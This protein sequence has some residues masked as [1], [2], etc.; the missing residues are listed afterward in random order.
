MYR[1]F[2]THLA[3]G[4]VLAAV[5]PCAQDTRLSVPP[6][7]LT[8]GSSISV[9]YE[10]GAPNPPSFVDV[11]IHDGGE[12]QQTLRIELNDNGKGSASWTV[13]E[14]S[15]AFFNATGTLEITRFIQ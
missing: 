2:F 5:A 11:T 9:S 4:L 7:P 6:G 15:V 3:V 1:F 14:W 8:A 10:H 13:P 12:Q